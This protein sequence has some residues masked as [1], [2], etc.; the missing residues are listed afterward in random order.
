M[1]LLLNSE[2]KNQVRILVVDDSQDKA[3]K[4]TLL[5]RAEGYQVDCANDGYTAIFR[6]HTNS[7][8]LVILDAMMPEI[9]GLEVAKWIRQNHSYIPILLLV[10]CQELFELSVLKRHQLVDGFISKP[11]NRQELLM[12]VRD[13]ITPKKSLSNS[14][15]SSSSISY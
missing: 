4:L 7:P 2:N 10:T 3:L 11:I 13:T 1:D 15:R 8:H 5:L 6:I 9:D 12:Q 14:I